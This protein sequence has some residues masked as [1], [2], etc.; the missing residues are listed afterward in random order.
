[1]NTDPWPKA[2]RASPNVATA[3]NKF[4]IM[5][6]SRDYGPK[7]EQVKNDEVKCHTP[8]KLKSLLENRQRKILEVGRV[9]SL[10]PSPCPLQTDNCRFMAN[11]GGCS[12][13][14]GRW[15]KQKR[16]A[17]HGGSLLSQF[18]LTVDRRRRKSKSN[19]A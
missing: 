19:V 13:H 14:A 10:I 11:P 5:S 1:M 2:A 3:S 17:T 8:N 16:S 15:L 4:F 7:S 12:P 18:N 9:N 6:L